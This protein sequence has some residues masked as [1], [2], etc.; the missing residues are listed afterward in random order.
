MA[1]TRAAAEENV[2]LFYP[3]LIGWLRIALAIASCAC[4]S[5]APAT[6]AALY[7]LSAF[8]DAFDGHLA[9][10]YNQGE[11]VLTAAPLPQR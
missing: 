3:N 8:L 10:V 2:F 9:R 4:M 11:C 6:A 7:A 5:A 1:S